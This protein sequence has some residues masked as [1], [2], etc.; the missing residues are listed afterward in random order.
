MTLPQTSKKTSFDSI[1]KSDHYSSSGLYPHHRALPYI[2]DWI[3]I[4]T[5]RKQADKKKR[6]DTL[7]FVMSDSEKS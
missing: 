4:K 7:H 2:E 6:A 5:E 1:A 3:A